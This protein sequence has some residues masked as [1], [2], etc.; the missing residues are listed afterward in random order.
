M[1]SC[2]RQYK[3]EVPAQSCASYQLLIP[4]PELCIIPAPASG[5]GGRSQSRALHHTSSCI[6]QWREIP[7]QSCASYQLLQPAVA[8]DPSPELRVSRRLL[9]RASFIRAR[10][11]RFL[12]G[13]AGGA[14]SIRF[15]TGRN[16]APGAPRHAAAGPVS[17]VGW[18]LRRADWAR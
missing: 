10:A 13:A 17:G 16:I 6:R 15:G 8:G 7:V 5:S 9:R 2:R 1:S 18:P 14:G 12:I 3:R 11:R 4:S